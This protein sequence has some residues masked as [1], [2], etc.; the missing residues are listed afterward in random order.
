MLCIFC[1]INIYDEGEEKVGIQTWTSQPLKMYNFHITVTLIFICSAPNVMTM[2]CAYGHLQLA[3]NRP[4]SS[5][6]FL[7]GCYILLSSAPP[8]GIPTGYAV[9]SLAGWQPTKKLTARTLWKY[10]NK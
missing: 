9:P 4:I 3:K 1:T 6:I 8:Q 5:W 2:L 7:D 10:M